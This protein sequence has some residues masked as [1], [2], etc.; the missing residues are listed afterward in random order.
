M[1]IV[2]DAM[3]SDT[4]PEPEVAAAAEAARLFGDK[5]F[6]VGPAEKLK[7]HLLAINADLNK[8][9]LVDATD[10]ITMDDKGMALVLKAK[11]PN[12]KTSMAV[13]IDLVKNNFARWIPTCYP[14]LPTRGQITEEHW[15]TIDIDGVGL[16]FNH[17]QQMIKF[18]LVPYD[19]GNQHLFSQFVG[20]T[21]HCDV[22]FII[23]MHP[24]EAAIIQL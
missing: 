14:I 3:G 9:I 13:G 20:C 2:L 7:T 10:T 8:I 1:R 6:L 21:R 18:P 24:F 22:P 15:F 19:I 11:R 16:V 17:D 12:S 4:C 5:L 23:K